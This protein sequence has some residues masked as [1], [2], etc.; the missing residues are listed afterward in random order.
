MEKIGTAEAKRKSLEQREREFND[1]S[2]Y[3]A[4]ILGKNMD[5]IICIA[6]AILPFITMWVEMKDPIF[7]V[8]M[9]SDAVLRIFM[10]I[11]GEHCMIRV[12]IAS[13]KMDD[14][15]IMYRQQFLQER[16]AVYAIG[17][18][19]MPCFCKWQIETEFNTAK[20][21]ALSELD[22]DHD[23][24]KNRFSKMNLWQ[25]IRYFG[26]F[27]SVDYMGIHRIN[28]MRRIKLT[29]YSIITDGSDEGTRGG[30]KPSGARYVKQKTYGI[31]HL[32]VAVLSGWCVVLS[33]FGASGD[34]SFASFVSAFVT[35]LAVIWRMSTGYSQ[36]VKAYNTIEVNHLQSK[37]RYLREYQEYISKKI[38]LNHGDRYGDVSEFMSAPQSIQVEETKDNEKVQNQQPDEIGT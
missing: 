17:I 19:P 18:L 12:G 34:V 21:L 36:G 14:E 37:I 16:E 10:F 11:V 23:E 3:T 8:R 7:S 25:L 13:G 35:F 20:Y 5:Y 15:H 38:Y 2:K 29:T 4:R 27:N 6:I 28:K 26:V 31:G 22:V 1:R 9:V 32:I 24:Y 30:V 33:Q